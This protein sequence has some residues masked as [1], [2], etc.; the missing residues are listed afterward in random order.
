VTFAAGTVIARNYLPYAR[1]LARSFTEHHGRRLSVLLLDD[2]DHDVTDEPFDVLRL[3]D[4]ELGPGEARRMAS[5]YDVLELATAVKPWLLRRLLSAGTAAMYLDPDM[6]VY[7]P[8]DDLGDLAREGGLV[9]TPHATSPVPRDGRLVEETS[10]LAAGVYNLGF[11]CVSERAGPFLDYWMVRL[12]RDCISEPTEMRFVDQRWVDFAPGMFP[13]RIVTDR[14]VNAAYWNVVDRPVSRR[15]GAWYAGDVRLRLYHF[16]G[17][18]PAAPYVLSTHQGDRPRILLSE[19]PGLAELCASYGAELVAA[20][21]GVDDRTPYRWRT[22]DNGLALDTTVRRIVRT[23]MLAA[24]A[25]EGPYPPDPFDPEGADQ[26]VRL[27]NEP[28]ATPEDPGRLSTYLATLYARTTALYRRFPDPQRGDRDRFF[29]WAAAEARAGR[30]DPRLVPGAPGGP[31]GPPPG[32]EWGPPGD[33]RPGVLV[34]GSLDA[35]DD[36]GTDARALVA[37]LAGADVAVS[38]WSWSAPPPSDGA[39]GGGPPVARDLDVTVVDVAPDAVGRFV[40]KAGPEFFDGRY[41]VGRWFWPLEELPA[42]WAGSLAPFREIWAATETA[43]RAVSARTDKPVHTV[44]PPVLAPD[45]APTGERPAE[46]GGRP[47]VVSVVDLRDEFELT[48]PDG[49]VRAFC[50]AF[51]AGEGP[52]LVVVAEHAGQAL[53]AAERLRYAAAGRDDVVIVDRPLGAGGRAALL[54]GA[55]AVVSLHRATAFGIALAQ[56]MALGTPVV[57]TGYS[58]NLEYMTPDTARLVPYEAG[59]VPPGCGPYPTGA[60]WAEPDESVAAR[61][62]ADLVADPESARALGQRGRRHVEVHHSP[63]A[64]RSLVVERLAAIGDLVAPPAPPDPPGQ[65]GLADLSA[66]AAR[67]LRRA[68]RVLTSGDEGQ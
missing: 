22:A 23:A 24:D 21:Y 33:L 44:A 13:C 3:D 47:T 48:N 31:P 32:E 54:A 40:Q 66:G 1:V 17:Y 58:G 62:L 61:L 16:S 60:R 55:D 12:R 8:L 34:A 42:E 52:V 64:R 30:I 14:G 45:L 11:C 25:G 35:D 26:L 68:A 59:R 39:A 5:I 51:S 65:K 19:H 6:V 15:G 38:R 2:P 56:A 63:A 28:P 18:S 43:R 4:L 36:A 53:V 29:E 50:S 67:R 27:M 9:L 20:G 49:A 7:A 57:A 10:L 46:L 41:N 37:C